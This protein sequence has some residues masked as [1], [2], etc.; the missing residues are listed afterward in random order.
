MAPPGQLYQS[1]HPPPSPLPPSLRNLDLTQRLRIL[2]DRMGMWH[3][4]APLISSL[5]RDGFNPSSIQEA[6]GISGV[7]QNCLIIASQVRDSLLDDKVAVFPPDLLPYFDS[8]G[9]P[10]LPYE[11]RFL[12]ARQRADAARHT[13]DYRLKP[14]GVQELARA[15]KSFLRW[16]GEEGWEAF[17]RDSPTDCL[18]YTRFCQSREAIDVEDLIAELERALQVVETEFGRARV[19]LELERARKKAVGEVEG[20]EEDPD[21]SRP[22]VTVVR[23]Q[24]AAMQ[25][26]ETE[27]G[28][29]RVELELERARKKAAGEV[30][31]EEED[32]ATSRP[33]VTVVRLQYGGVALAEATT[34]FMLPVLRETDG[35]AAMESA[36]KR[37]K[38]GVDLGIVEVDKAWARWAVVPRW[39]P[40][41]EAVDD[42]VVIELA[43]G[44]RLP[45]RTDD[46][47]LVLVIANTLLVRVYMSF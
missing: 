30:E 28:R 31:G 43:D 32:P 36:P 19:E 38:T 1:F 2:R 26:V 37:T 3:E 41:A 40:V 22:G 39:G 16:R 24:Y 15:M 44:Q 46:E 33:G 25:V 6:M 9:E 13:I 21:A 35:V 23:L 14:K 10:D 4:Y 47:E 7:E 45:W 8:Y 20:E 11:L 29:A 17:G 27:S 34:I 42:A 18:A 5:S 12:N